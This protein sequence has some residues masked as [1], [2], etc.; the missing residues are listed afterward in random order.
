[1]RLP[2]TVCF[3]RDETP[4][5]LISRLAAANRFLS[6]PT[7]LQ[8]LEIQPSAIAHGDPEAM[9][10][11][12]EL[13]GFPVD[14]VARFALKPDGHLRGTMNGCK[15][16]R[17]KESV[18]PIRRI[19]PLCIM[20][21][22][23]NGSGP[24]LARPYSRYQWQTVDIA[25]CGIHDVGLASVSPLSHLE[26]DFARFVEAHGDEIRETAGNLEVRKQP[27]AQKYISGRL[28]EAQVNPFLDDLEVYVV[29]DTCQQLGVFMRRH[30]VTELLP[31]DLELGYSVAS[32]GPTA[33]E[34]VIAATVE[35]AKP[36]KHT[37]HKFFGRMLVWLR[38]QSRNPEMS[39]VIEM[40]Q[41]IAVRNL[42]LSV[43][44]VFVTPV[45]RTYLQSV[46]SASTQYGL[47]K[48]V[49]R[50]IVSGAGLISD[51]ESKDS[52]TWFSAD[53]ARPVLEAATQSLSDSEVGDA[54]GVS[55]SLAKKLRKS[56]VISQ[57]FVTYVHARRHTVH[58]AALGEFVEKMFLGVAEA[59]PGHG[60]LNLLDATACCFCGFDEMVRLVVDRKLASLRR[61]GSGRLL[62]D[63]V[64]DWRE[65]SDI[66]AAIPGR[67]NLLAVRERSLGVRKASVVLNTT[68]LTVRGLVE[69]GQLQGTVLP[70]DV[71]GIR[72]LFVNKTSLEIFDRENIS[73]SALAYFLGQETSDVETLMS[74]SNIMPV[75]K[76]SLMR[77]PFYRRAEVATMDD[78][79]T[80]A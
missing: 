41:D 15:V 38:A 66:F 4:L 56:G 7:F 3:Q 67:E 76:V 31:D 65:A 1:M 64:L 11:L 44:D 60:L 63:L 6:L 21:D 47:R 5:S 35:T 10:R 49:V 17:T 53:A 52:R 25:T 68:Q 78:R 79:N 28:K 80:N 70:N 54:L 13:S 9:I 61:L 57:T 18:V 62:T 2:N 22:L 74:T 45:S 24:S 14:D 48:P 75:N 51:H 58:P 46:S 69:D 20:D 39:K 37:I 29:T 23:D 36:N 71:T 32:R 12:S 8:L 33:I 40:F 55:A 30:G 73:I 27:P 19:C 26:H 16:R 50:A 43:G 34:E 77:E 42:P 72:P 59:H